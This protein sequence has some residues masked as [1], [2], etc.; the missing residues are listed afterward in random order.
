MLIELLECS[1]GCVQINITL[2]MLMV[3]LILPMGDPNKL[4]PHMWKL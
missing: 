4:Y 3:G 1:E 2:C